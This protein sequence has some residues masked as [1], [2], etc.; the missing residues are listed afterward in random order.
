[1]ISTIVIAVTAPVANAGINQIISAKRVNDLQLARERRIQLEINEQTCKNQMQLQQAP[2]SCHLT[3]IEQHCRTG[4]M[5]WTV[6][7]LNAGLS[8]HDLSAECRRK[9]HSA[10]EIRIYQSADAQ[11]DDFGL[12]LEVRDPDGKNNSSPPG[13]L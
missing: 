7:E 9:L 6:E 5:Q 11:S 4:L 1:M 12:S 13:R 8:R 2:L 3:K 10:L